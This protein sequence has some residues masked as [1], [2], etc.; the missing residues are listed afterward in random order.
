MKFY[1]PPLL[2]PP[3]LETPVDR[4][5]DPLLVELL[6]VEGLLLLV[7]RDTFLLDLVVFLV[8]VVGLVLLVVEGL[9]VLVLEGL[10]LL[11]VEGL[12]VL[13]LYGLEFTELLV[14]LV[15]LGEVDLSKRSFLAV[16]ELV[17]RALSVCLAIDLPLRASL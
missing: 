12:V 10:V 11:V 15:D 16:N 14:V 1:I 7:E 4:V 17:L 5:E 6:V 3:P 9:I 13:V 8:V 2:E